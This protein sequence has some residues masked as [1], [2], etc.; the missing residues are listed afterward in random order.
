MFVQNPL[1]TR[2]PELIY[3]TGDIVYQHENG[4]IMYIGRKDFQIKHFGYRIDIGEIEHAVLTAF[5]SINACVIY[6]QSKREIILVYEAKEEI[7]ATDFRKQLTPLLSKYMIP[8]RYVFMNELPKTLNGK[9]DRT[10]LSKQ[11]GN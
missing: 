7:K 8:T 10:T 1:N 6:N 2:Y 4:N 9:I 11:L 5:G 3:R